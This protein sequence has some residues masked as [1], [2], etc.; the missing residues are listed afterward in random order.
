MEKYN[1]DIYSDEE[2]YEIIGYDDP[3]NQDLEVI[4]IDQLKNYMYDRTTSGIRMFNFLKS[5]YTHFFNV[6]EETSDTTDDFEN[7][8]E[9]LEETDF[10]KTIIETTSNEP[11][12]N[13]Y[14][15][16][17]PTN[18]DFDDDINSYSNQELY[19]LL[20]LSSD[21]E[22]AVLE[23]K[24]I[25]M[26]Q[27]Y[28][29]VNTEQGEKMY[30]FYKNIYDRFFT[31]Q[32]PDLSR[33][34]EGDE[35]FKDQFQDQ[36][37]LNTNAAIGNNIEY[38]KSI[39]YTPGKVNPILKETYKRTISIDSQYR[40]AEYAS[41]TNFTL[42]FT[43]TLKDVV[44]M[45]LYAVQI[46]VTWYTIS[47][48]YGSNFFYLKPIE[49]EN[50]LGIYDQESHIYKVEIEP[51]NYTPTTLTSAIQTQMTNL[52]TTYSDVSF[53]NTQFSY[54]SSNAKSTFNINLQKIY[55][56]SY[57]YLD[58]TNAPNS[59]TLLN[60][61]SDTITI[62]SVYSSLI[63]Y[64][65][66][67]NIASYLID[68]NINTINIIHYVPN[69]TTTAYD[70]TTSTVLQTIPITL[71]NTTTPITAS[72][73]LDNL[74]DKLQANAY[75]HEDS[76]VSL[77]DYD[78]ENDK[79]YYQWTIRLNRYTTQNVLYSKIAV[80][81]P[82]ATNDPNDKKLWENVF[83]A[84]TGTTYTMSRYNGIEDL[85]MNNTIDFQEDETI[86][87][88]PKEDQ[89]GGV[90]INDIMYSD[91]NDIVI[92][93]PKASYDASKIVQIINANINEIAEIKNTVFSIVNDSLFIEFNINKIYTTK[94]YALVFYDDDSFVKCTNVSNSYRNASADTT[95]GYILGYKELSIYELSESN[96]TATSMFQNPDTLM[97]TN[98][99]YSVNTIYDDDGL[100]TNTAITLK[101]NAT[102]NIYLYNYFMIILDD[103][104]Q[105][106]LNDGLVTVAKRDTSVTLPKYAN[107]KNYR[108]CDAVT[109]ELAS[110]ET[111]TPSFPTQ[112]L[113]QKQVYSVEQ[114]LAEQNKVREN[115]N[116][117]PFI[118]DMFALLPV[119]ASGATPGT[120]YVEFGGTLQQQERIY[121]GP[122]NIRRLTIKLI[123]DKGD[124]VDLNGANWSFQLVCEQL[125][126]RGNQGSP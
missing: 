111:E 16:S 47:S 85:S 100:I 72:E 121:F 83:E 56:E 27:L 38:S 32:E 2:L 62:N 95:L 88:R 45:K 70:S 74:N 53:G 86:V 31:N 107:R 123:N 50:T 97:P 42:N 126:S 124:V 36:T 55:N 13:V 67:Y 28:S 87:F 91:Y 98:S 51:G 110:P 3:A 94:D 46:P 17:M 117:G 48:N 18:P 93:I 52:S 34:Y 73:I 5:I 105:N 65:Y 21:P 81:F 19:N 80:I 54:D 89:S 120:I 82:D 9:Q 64:D 101:G 12:I 29:N 57:Y 108:A 78:L 26:L 24:I 40:D 44:S 114:I 75:L 66:S 125:Y 96:L 61:E 102:L 90:Y 33:D 20:D 106:H 104:N 69:G 71:D 112:G 92:N 99:E 41:A 15:V 35:E 22:D 37:V 60:I 79:K 58:F 25:Q 43:E 103:Y 116:S 63:D 77:I 10:D 115:M 84:G 30:N 8:L 119:K 76:N 23:A 6:A 122:V 68:D 109:G 14:D 4:L 7:S 11:P 49:N 113:T 118:K 1:I 39:D 59:K